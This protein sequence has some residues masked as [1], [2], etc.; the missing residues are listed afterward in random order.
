LRGF[1]VGGAKVSDMHCNFLINDQGASGQDVERLGETIRARVKDMSGVELRWEIIRL[2]E[3][4]A[5]E[6]VGPDLA[7]SS[8]DVSALLQPTSRTGT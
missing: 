4:V 5:D 7:L 3:P 1:R 6:V 8:S 2:G